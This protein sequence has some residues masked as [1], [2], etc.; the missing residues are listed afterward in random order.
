MSLKT[1][2]WNGSSELLL[3]L[4]EYV[5]YI[6]SEKVHPTYKR[7][8]KKRQKMKTEGFQKAILINARNNIK[9]K[10]QAAH[11]NR[12]KNANIMKMSVTMERIY[13]QA[14]CV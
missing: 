5:F 8:E 6:F 10:K 4:T 14:T 1:V 2:D 12:K 13:F 9:I 3:F 7:Q 11:S